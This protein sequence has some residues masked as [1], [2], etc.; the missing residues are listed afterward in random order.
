MK[1][2]WGMKLPLHHSWSQQQMQ[3]CGQIQDL[4]VSPLWKELLVPSGYEAGV[5]TEAVRILG[6]ICKQF[7]CTARCP[8]TFLTAVDLC[9]NLT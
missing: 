7:I 9:R 8:S 5:S 4:D 3:A 1:I 2:Y 6:K